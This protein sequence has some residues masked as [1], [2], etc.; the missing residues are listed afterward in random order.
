MH[1]ILFL[2]KKTKKASWRRSR[3]RRHET[4]ST[5]FQPNNP[6][7]LLAFGSAGSSRLPGSHQWLEKLPATSVPD[8][9]GGPAT[10]WRKLGTV[11][12]SSNHGGLSGLPGSGAIT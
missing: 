10:E 12:R 1:P 11:F 8:Y 2:F 3:K 6:I 5:G 9:S 7:R 4:L